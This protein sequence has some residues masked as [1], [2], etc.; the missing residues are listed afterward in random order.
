MRSLWKGLFISP[1]LYINAFGS[2]K[3]SSSSV[4]NVSNVVSR[5]TRILFEFIGT[6]FSVYNGKAFSLLKVS[7]SMVGFSF[8]DFIF[9]KKTGSRI[10]ASSKSLKK[11][12]RT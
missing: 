5:N 12:K 8:G 3:Q 9:T 6:E 2:Y 10:H 4:P 1:Q 11:P 7:S